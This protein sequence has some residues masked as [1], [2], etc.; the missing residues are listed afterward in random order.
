[1]KWERPEAAK[2]PKLGWKQM[3]GGGKKRLRGAGGAWVFSLFFGSTQFT[4]ACLTSWPPTLGQR[5]LG[6]SRPSLKG[7]PT[8]ILQSWILRVKNDQNMS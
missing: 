7:F 8:P 1:M 2:L 3:W 5:R 6:A 4:V